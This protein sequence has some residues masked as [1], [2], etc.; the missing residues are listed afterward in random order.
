MKRVFV[1][2][3]G[4]LIL[5]GETFLAAQ[6]DKESGVTKAQ[7]DKQQVVDIE[8]LAG[9]NG[10]LPIAKGSPMYNFY[11]D[12]LG[13]GITTPYI[14]WDGGTGY[15][16][17]LNTRIAAG[18]MP[19]LFLPWQ[20]N[21]IELILNG[22]IADLT[23]LLPKYAPNVWNAFSKDIWDLVK[24]ND[25]TN[26][27]RI[28]Y[29]PQVM[30][31]TRHAAFIR[32]DWLDKLGLSMPTTQEEYVNVLKAFKERD[33]NGNNKAD[34]L[35]TSGREQARW[36]DHLF[37]MYGVA[38]LEGFPDWDIYNGEITYSAVTPNMK[39]A[40]EFISK[41]YKDGLLD[42]ET[43]LNSSQKWMGKINQDL[44]GS[45]FHIPYELY[46]NA[47]LPIYQNTGKKP[48]I[49]VMPVPRVEGWAQGHTVVKKMAG[50]YWV[51]K[52]NLEEKKLMAVMQAINNW[53]DPKNYEKIIL[54]V[55]GMHWQMKDGKKLLLPDDKSK[56]QVRI[57]YEPFPL[58]VEKFTTK[59]SKFT[60]DDLMWVADMAIKNMKEA[61]K[62]GKQIAGDGLPSS[63]YVNYPEIQNRT[64]Y[65]EYASKIIIGQY[66]LDRFD[67][68]VNKWY[69][70]G[71]TEV[72]AR[73]REWYNKLRAL[74]K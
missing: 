17:V 71:G 31:M 46:T 48:N 50:P 18:A 61:G 62:Y 41:L 8:V 70:S 47:T 60:P 24:A 30:D 9:N 32:K 58:T 27:G 64:L 28:Y 15:L 6:G 1:M 72:T 69:K 49:E 37:N 54:G 2:C 67:E 55:E 20:G 33:P 7:A 3:L 44:V 52:N 59:Y 38:M 66:P 13:V 21:E 14:E 42:K 11:V 22:G 43:L 12:L 65:V 39:A 51:I 23:D 35:P 4:L 29:I 57:L 36:M 40:L 34:E 16:N 26:K 73:A 53:Y 25:P 68:F 74:A 19:E 5:G 56:M 63:I 45:W 10:Y